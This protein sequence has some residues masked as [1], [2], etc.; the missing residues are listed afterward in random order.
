MFHLRVSQGPTSGSCPDQ[1]ADMRP[2]HLAPWGREAGRGT[3]GLARVASLSRQVGYWT[4]LPST[5]ST[6][7]LPPGPRIAS[8]YH[9]CRCGRGEPARQSSDAAGVCG[10]RPIT[11]KSAMASHWLPKRPLHPATPGRVPTKIQTRSLRAAPS[12]TTVNVAPRHRRDLEPEVLLELFGGDGE[13]A[14]GGGGG[15]GSLATILGL[16]R[17]EVRVGDP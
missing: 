6:D 15:G 13:G 3:S 11:R 7:S 12:T 5:L 2:H 8:L 4:W 10:H 9:P 17:H 1:R 16:A 14:S